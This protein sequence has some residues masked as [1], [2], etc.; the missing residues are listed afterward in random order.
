MK[1]AVTLFVFVSVAA[2][3][4]T[5][6][7]V[8]CAALKHHGDPEARTCY[9][10]LTKSRD[11]G[12]QAEGYWGIRDYNSANEAFKIAVKDEPKDPGIRVRYGRMFLEHWQHAD[13]AQLF[14]EA[15][16]LRAITHR[17]WLG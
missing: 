8:R 3:G 13:A 7:P 14:G 6:D 15:L 12:I 17:L 1:F 10:N 16:F 2:S 4:Q 9:Q 11:P 5:L